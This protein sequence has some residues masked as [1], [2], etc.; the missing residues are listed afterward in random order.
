MGHNHKWWE[1]VG[2]NPGKLWLDVGGKEWKRGQTWGILG[3]AVLE[4]LFF[5]TNNSWGFHP[6]IAMGAEKS[7]S[8]PEAHC[9][10]RD[11][12]PCGPMAW[13]TAVDFVPQKSSKIKVFS[14]QQTVSDFQ[15]KKHTSFSF[16]YFPI[17]ISNPNPLGP[18]AVRDPVPVGHSAVAKES[19]SWSPQPFG[20]AN[21]YRTRPVRSVAKNGKKWREFLK[22]WIW[23]FTKHFNWNTP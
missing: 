12:G 3:G 5:L 18:E 14:K 16:P 10:T 20:T 2:N 19:Q 17:Q 8:T 1:F 6:M 4:I 11:H 13:G 21:L 7:C 9:G 15:R 22:P 23:F